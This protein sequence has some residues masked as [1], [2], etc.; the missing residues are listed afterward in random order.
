MAAAGVGWRTIE[1]PSTQPANELVYCNI[2]QLKPSHPAW[3]QLARAGKLV[4]NTKVPDRVGLSETTD[5]SLYQV[6]IQPCEATNWRTSLQVRLQKK[7]QQELSKIRLQLC[8][9]LEAELNE[10]RRELYEQSQLL[11]NEARKKTEK[12][13]AEQ[14]RVLN[15]QDQ[16]S[17]TNVAI[18]LQA[19]KS[20][21]TYGDSLEEELIPEI[22]AR[23][24]QLT[25]VR[26]KIETDEKNLKVKAITQLIE[27]SSER[28]KS[29]D[30]ALG[31]TESQ[32][33]LRIE[34][35]IKSKNDRLKSAFDE[36]HPI[37][38]ADYGSGPAGRE[39]MGT[40][41]A[42]R[43]YAEREMACR[44]FSMGAGRSAEDLT[45]F[46]CMLDNR[47]KDELQSVV[48]RLARESGLKVTF[49]PEKKAEDRTDWF[50]SRLPYTATSQSFLNK[51]L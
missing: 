13:L 28:R 33:T 27:A 16:F 39:S 43:A 29:I 5:L 24:D 35:L 10:K 47:I 8:R 2:D 46:R 18:K 48:R 12:E 41:A 11:D 4:L 38:P 36:A 15:E 49:T 34:D 17:S 45:R 20:R 26:A 31:E 6:S 30:E 1:R 22:K 37:Q 50:R 9:S 21:L 32:Q 51:N 44:A 42:S 3:S 14:L 25:Q 23:E 7:T 19:L 40:S